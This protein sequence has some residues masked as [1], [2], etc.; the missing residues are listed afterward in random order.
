MYFRVNSEMKK[1]T[2]SCCFTWIA[3]IEPNIRVALLLIKK[4]W[5]VTWYALPNPPF[6]PW[7]HGG[8][9]VEAPTRILV[10][11]GGVT[12]NKQGDFF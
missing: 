9:G 8:E 6:L 7:G 1:P 10:F 3:F 11:R 12:G 4:T 5:L 2:L